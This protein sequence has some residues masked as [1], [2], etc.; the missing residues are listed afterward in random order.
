VSGILAWLGVQAHVMLGVVGAVISNQS[1]PARQVV[2][3]TAVLA[4]LLYLTPKILKL[5]TK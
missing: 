5:V 1:A 2:I 3:Y 4:A